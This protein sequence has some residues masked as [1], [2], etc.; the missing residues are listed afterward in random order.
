MK[1]SAFEVGE[2]H[3]QVTSGPS[4]PY[5]INITPGARNAPFGSLVYAV[6]AK[7]TPTTLMRDFEAFNESATH[8]AKSLAQLREKPC[9]VSCSVALGPLQI[10]QILAQVE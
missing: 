2:A 5:S 8:L 10:R 9:F 3:V 6:P 1:T 4:G 7:G